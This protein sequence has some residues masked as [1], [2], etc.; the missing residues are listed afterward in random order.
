MA[1]IA[2]LEAELNKPNSYMQSFKQPS[3]VAAQQAA[4]AKDETNP[5]GFDNVF[6]MDDEAEDRAN[7]CAKCKYESRWCKHRKL[8]D[9]NKQVQQAVVTSAQTLGWRE[10]YDNFTFGNNRTGMCKRTFV[11]H[12][13]L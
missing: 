3:A 11:D 7:Y 13:H 10:P 9:D 2:E 6:E 12:G 1:K 8:R 4:I 5:R